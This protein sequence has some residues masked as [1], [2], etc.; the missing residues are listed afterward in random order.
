MKSSLENVFLKIAEIFMFVDYVILEKR[1]VKIYAWVDL[2]LIKK[3]ILRIQIVLCLARKIFLYH[4]RR[5]RSVSPVW[6]SSDWRKLIMGL[7]LT[8]WR[9]KGSFESL[10]RHTKK[11]NIS[12]SSFCLLLMLFMFPVA[13]LTSFYYYN[14]R[15]FIE[16]H[17]INSEG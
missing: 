14:A 13:P 4:W 11:C 9:S 7:L 15:G 2:E 8:S 16:C 17:Q 5:W 1:K 10:H 3:H 12:K 6:F